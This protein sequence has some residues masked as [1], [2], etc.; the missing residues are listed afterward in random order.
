M[1]TLQHVESTEQINNEV[2]IIEDQAKPINNQTNKESSLEPFPTM[3]V[4]PIHYIDHEIEK[5]N[6]IPKK[7]TTLVINKI[8]S[9][10][11]QKLKEEEKQ[12]DL[13]LP[14]NNYT[15]PGTKIFKNIINNQP[16]LGSADKIAYKHDIEYSLA[17][18]RE[19]IIYS[20]IRAIKQNMMTMPTSFTDLITKNL[21]TVGLGLKT[22]FY[23]PLFA[24]PDKPLL[25][26][27][28]EFLR[29]NYNK[30]DRD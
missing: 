21:M 25:P 13:T 19:D 11:A 5:V 30:Y 22:I 9:P 1:Q 2:G 7:D 24:K 29:A 12:I 28:E 4:K 20:D 6:Y 26:E 10:L 18:S 14:F 17:K 15:G 23:D 8:S 27:Q 3:G 16:P